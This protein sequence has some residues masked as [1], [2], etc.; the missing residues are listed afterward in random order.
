MLA[1]GLA[2]MIGFAPGS[3][4]ISKPTIARVGEVGNENI[5]RAS[6]VPQTVLESST[7]ITTVL[8]P[9]DSVQRIAA[10]GAGA[11][12]NLTINLVGREGKGF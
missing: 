8:N 7:G 12:T 5:M 10:A 6:Q 2:D 4:F 11:T 1:G 3:N 9:G